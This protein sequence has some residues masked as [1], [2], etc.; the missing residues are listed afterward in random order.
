M[1]FGRP[2]I[3]SKHPEFL[4]PLEDI[5]LIPIDM[6]KEITEKGLKDIQQTSLKMGLTF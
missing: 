5:P 2:G 6:D 1:F 4:P 3:K